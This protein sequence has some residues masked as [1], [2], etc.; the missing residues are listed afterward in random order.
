MTCASPTAAAC[1]SLGQLV[2]DV[3]AEAVDTGPLKRARFTGPLGMLVT[4]LAYVNGMG[5][6]ISLVL[7]R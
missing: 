5:P 4:N 7:V 1:A 3:G 6:A 2:T